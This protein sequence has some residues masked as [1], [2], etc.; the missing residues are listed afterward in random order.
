VIVFPIWL[1]VRLLKFAGRPGGD[2]LDFAAHPGGDLVDPTSPKR[3][4]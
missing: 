4:A 3:E 1:V 2:L